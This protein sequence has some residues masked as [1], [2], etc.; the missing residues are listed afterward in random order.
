MSFRLA[1]TMEKETL[2]MKVTDIVHNYPDGSR[3]A[4]GLCRVR[5]FVN[6]SGIVVLLT[7]LGNKND[8]Q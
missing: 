3:L 6:E 4:R 2:R 5:S 8:G 1:H 7:D